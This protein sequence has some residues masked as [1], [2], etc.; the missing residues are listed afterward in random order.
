MNMLLPIGGRRFA[1][2]H[3]FGVTRLQRMNEAESQFRSR[4]APR[5]EKKS[6]GTIE[7]QKGNAKRHGAN[8]M[9]SKSRASFLTLLS[10]ESSGKFRSRRGQRQKRAPTIPVVRNVLRLARI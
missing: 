1:G 10:E 2:I 6:K 7:A 3:N 9:M 5:D 4:P 8:L